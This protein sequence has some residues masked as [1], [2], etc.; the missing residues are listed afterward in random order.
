MADA[1]VAQAERE[2]RLFEFPI[3]RRRASIVRRRGARRLGNL[4]RRTRISVSPRGRHDFPRVSVSRLAQPRRCVRNSPTAAVRAFS[5]PWTLPP[6]ATLL[7]KLVAATRTARS[8]VL[9]GSPQR[10]PVGR[11]R[12]RRIAGPGPRRRNEIHGHRSCC[13]DSFLS[14]VPTRCVIERTK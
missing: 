7:A 4:D 6:T 8:A 12:K 10:S 3:N 1:G 2:R 5:C 11:L 14:S 13:R 9:F